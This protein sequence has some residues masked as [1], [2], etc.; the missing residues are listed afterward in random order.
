SR[1]AGVYQG[2]LDNGGERVT[3]SIYDVGPLS[4]FEYNDARGWPVAADG[5][6]HALVPNILSGQTNGFLYYGRHWRPGS[7]LDG[8]P[9][10][11]DLLLV[12]SVLLNE[13]TAHTDNLDTN[14][15]PL[16]DSDDWI[17]LINLT[18][19][20][21]GL[22]DW[23]L[24]DDRDD[25]KKWAIPATNLIAGNSWL[26][27][28]ETTGF[29]NPITTGFGL[30]KAGEQVFLS[31]LPGTADDRVA[32]A[33][34]FKG[35]ENGVSLG[36]F[37]DGVEWWHRTARTRDAANALTAQE[38]VI[39]EFMYH[40]IPTLMN[41][42]DNV[43]D[44][45]I[46][47]H[48]PTLAAVNLWNTQGPWRIDGEVAFTF[49]S[50]TVLAAGESLVLVSFDPT[51]TNA[52]M[53]F[54][55]TYGLTNGAAVIL[56]PYSGK[57]SNRGG[58]LA[59]ERL[60]APD[61]IGDNPSWVI[62]DEAIYFDR[63][64]WASEPDGDGIALHRMD[65]AITGNDPANWAAGSPTPGNDLVGFFPSVINTDASGIGR[66]GATLGGSLSST[67]TAATTVL[68]YWGTSD[69]IQTPANWDNATDLGL[70]PT[71]PLSLAVTGLMENTVYYYRYFATNA[72]GGSWAASTTVFK[73][74][75]LPQIENTAPL[76]GIG[77]ANLNGI[78]T[79]GSQAEITIYY[80]RTDGAT[81]PSSW[82]HA[83]SLGLLNEGTFSPLA[84]GLY[85]GVRYYYRA[86]ATNNAGDTW[87]NATTNLKTLRPA[88][89]PT[90]S[91]AGWTNTGSFNIQIDGMIH[92]PGSVYDVTLFHGDS[93]GGTNVGA[94][95]NAITVGRYTNISH[96]PVSSV[97]N[98]LD[99]LSVY[100]TFYASNCAEQIWATPSSNFTIDPG[101]FS[102]SNFNHTTK[103]TFCGYNKPET[104]S[105]F[106]VLVDIGPQIPGFSY[107]Q[108]H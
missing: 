49:P 97:I 10:L 96:S 88:D 102:P 95:E 48:N 41:P 22:G 16:H 73:T 45:Y 33:V 89:T 71:G 54:N 38:P 4:D 5:A 36:R 85:Y 57:L 59:L 18:G 77:E 98:D 47:I 15:F 107:N 11:P 82:E 21:I 19:G 25:L 40:P 42:A 86:Y 65:D 81:N 83:I 101:P 35:Q 79:G 12:P 60:Q 9:G 37:P 94:W 27:F 99:S 106:P 103:L 52:F 67:G 6:G 90:I 2:D 74:T 8:S 92:F 78:L 44:E 53:N 66:F 63:F 100:Y 58:R 32:D 24:S 62:V 30:N 61:L 39:S 64:P 14:N 1:I 46:E 51:D 105:N 28:D 70:N 56:G 20:D 69:G 29:H 84:T 50:N 55:T 3:L 87:A 91:N 17:E 13:V 93:D 68:L 104:L 75:G 80:G 34:R 108:L 76:P 72:I 7:Y 23:Y 43:A 26:S 31:Y